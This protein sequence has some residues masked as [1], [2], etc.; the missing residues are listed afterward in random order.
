MKRPVICDSTKQSPVLPEFCDEGYWE[1]PVNKLSDIK[2]ANRDHAYILPDESVWVLNHEGTGMVQINAG[3]SSG[4]AQPTQIIN[5]DGNIKIIGSGTYN[6]QADLDMNT[7]AT[8]LGMKEIKDELETFI[9]HIEDQAIHVTTEEKMIW[10][11]KQEGLTAGEH[12]T[13]ENNVISAELPLT[14]IETLFT[15]ESVQIAVAGNHETA[16]AAAFWHRSSEVLTD[17]RYEGIYLEQ[18]DY[19]QFSLELADIDVLE[20]YSAV[21]ISKDSAS[22]RYYSYQLIQSDYK[23]ENEKS[24]CYIRNKPSFKTVNGQSLIGTG[25][26][27]ATGSSNRITLANSLDTDVDTEYS[28]TL[29]EVKF[30]LVKQANEQWGVF[31]SNNG[32]E[33]ITVAYYYNHFYDYGSREQTGGNSRNAPIVLK[34]EETSKAL[35]TDSI[36]LGYGSAMLSTYTH[37]IA[38]IRG[39]RQTL[40]EMT[41]MMN[42][43]AG[44][45][46]IAYIEKII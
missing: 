15:E 30:S 11:N 42:K 29:D 37:F 41:S 43:S 25:D 12:I 9:E 1:V 36:Y 14:V 17:K 16:I 3:G 26:I 6:V 33:D 13:I 28:A 32:V 27:T 5:K 46:I 34:F 4:D 18:E 22:K 24:P 31:V 35:D 10:N 21:L 7:L 23:E 8:N 20:E 39:D 19:T 40:Y 2:E 44:T 38:V 45:G